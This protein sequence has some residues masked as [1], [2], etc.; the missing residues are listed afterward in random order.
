MKFISKRHLLPAILA[1]AF[2]GASSAVL[3]QS[4]SSKATGE[5]AG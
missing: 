3:A 4:P 2:A 5:C 1:A